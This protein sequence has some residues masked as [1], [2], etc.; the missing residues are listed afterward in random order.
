MVRIVKCSERMWEE[1][2]VGLGGW[3]VSSVGRC[4]WAPRVVGIRRH[5]RDVMGERYYTILCLKVC[6][7]RA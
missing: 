6:V 3:Y 1:I 2:E 5:G 7:G 4:T